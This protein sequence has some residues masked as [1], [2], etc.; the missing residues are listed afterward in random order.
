MR[1]PVCAGE[2]YAVATM[3]LNPLIR[4]PSGPDCD[5]S[6]MMTRRMTLVLPLIAE[7]HH[8]LNVEQRA[9]ACGDECPRNHE[10][11]YSPIELISVL[12][13]SNTDRVHAWSIP[14][15]GAL[16]E[17]VGALMRQGFSVCWPLSSLS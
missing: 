16:S 17:A 10:A 13:P 3:S 4:A 15:I 14:V 11:R 1:D 2:K 6:R 9:R 8:R 7:G 12:L 5:V